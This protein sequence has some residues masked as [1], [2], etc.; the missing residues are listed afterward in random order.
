MSYVFERSG[1]E[2]RGVCKR[3]PRLSIYLSRTQSRAIASLFY[4]RH[5]TC[6]KPK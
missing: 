1:W 2:K 3:L 4:F 6:Q 5:S